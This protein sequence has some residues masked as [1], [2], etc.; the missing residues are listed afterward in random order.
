MA[1]RRA[2]WR[3][4]L[5]LL[6]SV[7]GMGAAAAD[8]TVWQRLKQGGHA[9]LIRHALAPGGGDPANFRIGD[10]GTQRNLNDVGRQQARRIGQ[11]LRRRGIRFTEIRTS[12]WC[13]CRETAQLIAAE[14]NAGNPSPVRV[15]DWT[16]LNSFFRDRSTRG[17]QTRALAQALRQAMPGTVLLL[18]THQVNITALTD[19][20]PSSGEMLVVKTGPGAD[21]RPVGRIRTRP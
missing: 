10:C 2:V 12:Q 15:L 16:V 6:A 5:T 11:L 4:G 20:F 9:I 18:V 17:Q 19:V 7:A 13:R 8:A 1:A 3:I 21:F 14:L